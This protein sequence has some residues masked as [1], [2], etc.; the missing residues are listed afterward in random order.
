MP[1]YSL[2]NQIF[3]EAGMA[4]RDYCKHNKCFGVV[5]TTV[6]S[7]KS[8]YKKVSPQPIAIWKTNGKAKQ[9]Y[10]KPNTGEI[11]DQETLEEKGLKL[12]TNGKWYQKKDS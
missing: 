4:E 3:E 1:G 6:G 7:E 11:F 8:E 9:L 2:F 12:H 10:I 5:D